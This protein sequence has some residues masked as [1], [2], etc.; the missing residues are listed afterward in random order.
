MKRIFTALILLLIAGIAFAQD[1]DSLGTAKSFAAGLTPPSTDYS[2]AYLSQIFG[3]VGNV[4]QGASGQILGKMFAIFNKGVLVVAALWLGMTTVQV[5]LRAATEG[6][7]MGQNKSVHMILLRI[8]LG[9]GL[10]IPSSATGYSVLQDVFMKIVVEGVALADQTWNAA[11]NYLEYGGNLY[12]PPSNMSNDTSWIQQSMGASALLP[13]ATPTDHQ[14][15]F[16]KPATQVFQDE[17]CMIL[18]SSKAWNPS[19]GKSDSQSAFTAVESYDPVYDSVTGRIGFPGVDDPH[20]VSARSAKCGFVQSYYCHNNAQFCVAG[21]TRN[22]TPQDAQD[23][24]FDYS[25]SAI[26][27]LV[28]AMMPAAKSYVDQVIN[29]SQYP[30]SASTIDQSI[31]KQMFSALL[32]YANLITPYQNL[33]SNQNQPANVGVI[34]AAED[35]GWIMA[36]G[37]YWQVEQLNK[38]SATISLSNLLPTVASPIKSLYT[39]SYADGILNQTANYPIGLVNYI[40][41][42]WAQYVG[43]QQNTVQGAGGGGGGG[44]G[45]AGKLTSSAVSKLVDNQ[46]NI[47][48]NYNPIV[49]LMNEGNSLINTVA[50]IW[51]AAIAITAI[52]AI[53]AGFCNS[54]SPGGVILKTVLSWMKSIIMFVTSALLIPGAILAFY[55]PMYPFAVFIFAAIGWIGMV[56]EGMAAAPLV[57]LGMT[58]PEGHDF[59]GKAEQ[60]LMLFLSIFLRPTLM[61]IGMIAFMVVSFVAFK[62]LMTAYTTLFG[63]LGS[64]GAFATLNESGKGFVYLITEVS[65]LVIFGFMAMEVVEQCTKLI[66]QVPNN[67]N[68]WIGAPGMGE[69]YG[70]MAAGIKGAVSTGAEQVGKGVGEI[71]TGAEVAGMAPGGVKDAKDKYDKYKKDGNATAKKQQGP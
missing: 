37:F 53:P 5:A 34:T 60:A 32:G 21:V 3:T 9:F 23:A 17:V 29:N 6:S 61:V 16:L 67:I 40:G 35:Q 46:F 18:S 11:L 50:S 2:I 25:Y 20:D 14:I 4:L 54:T 30:G 15:D 39:K 31:A 58:H 7:F 57:C 70:Q 22:S 1:G 33:L 66:Y 65:V 47:G 36:G 55:V 68:K 45:I 69:E 52:L 56:L 27:Q 24:E 19:T 12:I 38:G 13:N 51:S 42:L 63:A 10:I 64:Q 41:N 48:S 44:G 49:V 71:Q 28:I 43:A 62:M 8:A 26:K 59:L